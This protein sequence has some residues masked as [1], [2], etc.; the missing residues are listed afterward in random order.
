[1]LTIENLSVRYGVIDA[2]QHVSFEL[3]PGEII[4]LIGENGAGKSSLMKSILRFLPKCEGNIL[5]DGEP[6][7]EKNIERIAF[8]TCEH[9]FF[10]SLTPKEHQ[11]FYQ[12]QFPKFD[13]TRF[14]SLMKFFELPWGRKI[15][16]YS[17]GQKN[18]F[19]VCLALSQGAD[20]ILMDDP[21]AG[22]DIFLR[23]DF[24]QVLLGIMKENECIVISTHLIEEVK[25]L[26][27]RA[28]LLH[29]GKLIEDISME[30]FSER[31]E[32]FL[33]YLKSRYQNKEDKIMEIIQK[34]RRES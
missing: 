6:I 33:D 12:M 32:D 13:E 23:E 11:E 4:G 25:H 22:N 3:R 29:K 24:Y 1:M 26:I 17:T 5:L 16:G 14:I 18:Q 2:V 19:E 34:N 15:C 8:A 21:F 31:G 10:P 28:I 7:T 20:Y 30:D 9:S 27:S